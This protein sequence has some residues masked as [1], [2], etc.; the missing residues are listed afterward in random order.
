MVGPIVLTDVKDTIDTEVAHVAE[1]HHGVFCRLHLDLLGVSTHERKYRVTTGRWIEI[2]HGAYRLAGAPRTWKG[3][4]QAACWAGGTRAAISHRSAAAIHAMPGGTKS[5]VELTCPRWR[6]TRHAGL[7]VHES[8]A[9]PD[10]DIVLVEGIA[11]TT[12]SR[13]LFDLGSVCGPRTVDL[14]IDNAL[15]R[16]LTDFDRLVAMLRRLGHRG[17]EGTA[18]FRRLLADRDPLRAP[19]ESERESMLIAVLRSHGLPEPMRQH[20]IR[21]PT[22][23]FVARV[24][25]A[26]PDA[27]VA[28]EYE[29]YQHHVGKHALVRDSRR[30][31]AITA[32]GWTVLSGTAEDVRLGHGHALASAVGAALRAASRTGV[33][34]DR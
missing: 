25:I 15:R 6:R 22:G 8:R 21:D 3:D 2:H 33:I 28:I 19:T 29:S 24:D 12:V 5:F 14:A 18:L 11:V 7:V 16:E 1:Q 32:L 10:R 13:T 20:V 26:Y 9:L 34:A 23:A 31:N 17:V 4:A 27:K 30:R